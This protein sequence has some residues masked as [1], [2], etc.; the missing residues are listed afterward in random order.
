MTASRNSPQPSENW[1]VNSGQRIEWSASPEI[2]SV[3]IELSRDG[4]LSYEKLEMLADYL[5]LEIIIRPRLG[6]MM[7]SARCGIC[8]IC[9]PTVRFRTQDCWAARR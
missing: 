7:I 5:K 6:R 4:G 9:C 2:E 1:E 8:L 3:K